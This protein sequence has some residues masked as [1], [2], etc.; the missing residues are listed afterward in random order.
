MVTPPIA[1]ARGPSA[2]DNAPERMPD[3]DR[4]RQTEPDFD[5]DHRVEW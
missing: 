5:F 2:W 3:W 4:F 1:T